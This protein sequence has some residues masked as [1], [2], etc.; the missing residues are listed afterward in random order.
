MDSAS[1]KTK[2]LAL[3]LHILGFKI[4]ELST[5]RVTGRLPVSKICCQPFKVLHGGVSALIAESLASIGA[6]MA[7]NLK[8]VAGIQLSINHLKSADL[9]EIVF[10]QA[11]PVSSGRTIQVWEVKLWKSRKESHNKTLISSSRVTLLCNLPTP[12]HAKNASDPLK[13]ISKL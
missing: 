4:D 5:T 6:Y 9:G 13:M 3:P 7:T 2:V 8:R 11:S 10:A 12:G 1:S